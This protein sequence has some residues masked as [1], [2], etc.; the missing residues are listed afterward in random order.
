VTALHRFHEVLFLAASFST[1]QSVA[2]G[3]KLE[4]G[5]LVGLLP[6]SSLLSRFSFFLSLARSLAPRSS[7]IR[8]SYIKTSKVPHSSKET[9]VAVDGISGGGWGGCETCLG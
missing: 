3:S 8:H 1:S 9:E 7:L 6:A 4:A 2:G 5:Q